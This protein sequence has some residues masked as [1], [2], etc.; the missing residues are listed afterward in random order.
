MLTGFDLL[1][2]YRVVYLTAIFSITGNARRLLINQIAVNNFI[3]NRTVAV[4]V[5]HVPAP[6]L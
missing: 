6:F 3:V 5:S 2:I 4:L 1:R